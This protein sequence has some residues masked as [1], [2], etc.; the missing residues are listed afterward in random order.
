ME[1]RHKKRVL[2]RKYRSLYVILAVIVVYFL[3]F[4]YIPIV[5]GLIMSFQN[6][7]IGNTIVNAEWVGIHNYAAIFT[8]ADLLR[9]IKNTLLLSV[10]RL[11]WEFWPSILLAIFI[12]DLASRKFK[13]LAQTIVYIPNFFSWVVIY[14]F[15]FAFFSGNGFFNGLLTNLGFDKVDFL[16]KSEYFRSLLIGSQLWKG[17]GW[18]TILYFAA[19]TT[20]DPD[21]YAQCKIDG[22]GP[23]RRTMAVTL[24]AMMPIILFNLILS[25]GN[26]LNNDFEQVLLFYNSAVYDVGDIIDTWV[27]RVGIGQL[28]YSTGAAMGILKSFVGFILIVG[29]NAISRKVSER[30][31]W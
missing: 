5:M 15:V 19:L 26:I 17:I 8:N 2:F 16:M 20:V 28:Q 10:F 13:R 25:L 18:G 9:P 3:V 23:I 29:A 22:A 6:F 12:F 21:L 7:T 11:L 24:P 14:G 4:S 30:G 31:L 1:S 27:Y